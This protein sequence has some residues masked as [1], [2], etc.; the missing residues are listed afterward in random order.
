MNSE[1]YIL[2]GK[3]FLLWTQGLPTSVSA[4]LNFGENETLECRAIGKIGFGSYTI[5]QK[6]Q[7][8]YKIILKTKFSEEGETYENEEL[9]KIEALMIKLSKGTYELEY[10]NRILQLVNKDKVIFTFYLESKLR[11]EF[12]KKIFQGC[13]TKLKNKLPSF[14]KKIFVYYFGKNNKKCIRNFVNNLMDIGIKKSNLL[15]D[16]VSASAGNSLNQYQFNDK[17]LDE[18]DIAIVIGSSDLKNSDNYWHQYTLSELPSHKGKRKTVMKV[19]FTGSMEDNFPKM[20]HHFWGYSLLNYYDDFFSFVAK[21]YQL[22]PIENIVFQKNNMFQR[23]IENKESFNQFI[24]KSKEEYE[25]GIDN[26][27]KML[28]LIK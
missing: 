14:D 3:K 19:W 18:S 27:K 13:L 24:L 22:D 25:E 2:E 11:K 8:K 9:Y 4:Y 6:K 12:T 26:L 16:K 7:K 1:K 17:A 5:K 28:G 20:Y 21:L 10:E 15:Y 23:I